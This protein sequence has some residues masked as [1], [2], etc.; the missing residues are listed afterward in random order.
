LQAQPQKFSAIA[1]IKKPAC[2][3]VNRFSSALTPAYSERVNNPKPKIMA[4]KS[5]P[6]DDSIASVE[7]SA[8][9]DAT[10]AATATVPADAST[11]STTDHAEIAVANEARDIAHEIEAMD[12]SVGADALKN[13]RRRDGPTERKPLTAAQRQKLNQKRIATGKK[14]LERDAIGVAHV[15]TPAEF[16]HKALADLF[17]R[18]YPAIDSCLVRFHRSG[19]SLLG[20]ANATAIRD[21]FL[22]QVA[23]LKSEVASSLSSA[24]LVIENAKKSGDKN[25]EISL[26]YHAAFKNDV[27][28]LSPESRQL[29][30]VFLEMDRAMSQHDLLVW[31]GLRLGTDVSSEFDRLRTRVNDIGRLMSRTLNAMLQKLNQLSNAVPARADTA[32]SA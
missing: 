22:S 20:E 6:V 30:L 21:N 16:F 3:P 23:M 2:H 29:L 1:F 10:A 5:T 26:T 25:A 14:L 4:K 15:S 11:A 7:A 12:S 18:N 17:L 27:K 32:P 19:A 24:Q 13:P 8:A 9:A 28:S 31:S